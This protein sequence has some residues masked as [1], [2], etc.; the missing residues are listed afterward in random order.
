MFQLIDNRL[1]GKFEFNN[2]SEAVSFITKIW[3]IADQDNHHPDILL[4]WYNK[5]K[6]SLTTHDIW[7]KVWP[8][9]Y[10]LAEKIDDLFRA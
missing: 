4:H 2:F 8:K 9:D 10:K 3:I 7:S 6:V 1:E 5:L